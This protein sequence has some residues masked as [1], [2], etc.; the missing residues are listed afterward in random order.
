MYKFPEDFNIN[1][2]LGQTLEMICFN[3]NQIYLHFCDEK[4]VCIECDFEYFKSDYQIYADLINI[5]V[6]TSDLMQ[7]L[8][9]KI[10]AVSIEDEAILNFKFDNNQRLRLLPDKQYEGFK[11]KVK[12]REIII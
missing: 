8:E 5:P 12:G 4:S 6:F 1:V 3:A 10:T 2:F 11:I 7:L 9:C